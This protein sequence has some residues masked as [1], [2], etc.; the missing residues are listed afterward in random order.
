[1][2]QHTHAEQYCYCICAKNL[3]FFDKEYNTHIENVIDRFN[4]SFSVSKFLKTK[5][6]VV[7]GKYVRYLKK[8]DGN[9]QYS[10]CKI[11]MFH[12][13]KKK[14]KCTVYQRH[15]NPTPSPTSIPATPRQNKN[16][17]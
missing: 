3:D 10:T 8:A 1:M 15:Q 6:Y 12:F 4:I 9:A 5:R 17:S 2:I 11:L 16:K 13:N 14:I 7:Y